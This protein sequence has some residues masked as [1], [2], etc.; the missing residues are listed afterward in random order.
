MGTF[1]GAPAT[2]AFVTWASGLHWPGK[3]VD[4]PSPSHKTTTDVNWS[5]RGDGDLSSHLLLFCR[6]WLGNNRTADRARP[7]TGRG[8][9]SQPLFLMRRAGGVQRWGAGSRGVTCHGG[10][11]A[12][13]TGGA[14]VQT[15]RVVS[16]LCSACSGQAQA[17]RRGRQPKVGDPP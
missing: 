5:P 12:G 1:D 17:E 3:D 15:R 6:R 7:R 4:K 9:D 10:R 11:E 8:A 14:G 16:P 2:Q 13:H